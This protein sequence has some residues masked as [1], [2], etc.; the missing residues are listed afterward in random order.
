MADWENEEE[1]EAHEGAL[2]EFE[3]SLREREPED[4]SVEP[5]PDEGLE[6]E[7]G[8]DED[9]GDDEGDAGE[10]KTRKEKKRERFAEM[11]EERDRARE[12]MRK[13]EE[14]L[15]R[16]E[17]TAQQYPDPQT[18]QQR[19]LS[20]EPE[21]PQGPDPLEQELEDVYRQQTDLAR[22]YNTQASRL[23]QQEVQQYQER[24]RKLEER[25]TELLFQK[26]AK[27][28][29]MGQQANPDQIAQQAY[30]RAT[31][32][33]I[34]REHEDVYKN[35]QAV[36]WAQA[37]YQLARNEGM[38]DSWSTL[39]QVMDEARQKFGLRPR[40]GSGPT[41]S[42][43]SRYTGAPRGGGNVSGKSGRG[44]IRMTPE[45]QRMADAMYP[46]IEDDRERYQKWANEVGPTLSKK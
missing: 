10:R 15:A 45:Y 23:T 21:K 33:Q 41:P 44:T 4:R 1:R 25:R 19:L 14:R 32:A 31:Q 34:Q 17:Q 16:I 42:Q 28:N 8:A 26:A 30:V 40:R 3:K 13:M 27:K 38:P 24:A 7:V 35:P 43:R 46:H 6:L 36:S 22:S 2:S 20:R 11:R 12:E 18:L 39:N 29:G 9:D 37:R 5:Q